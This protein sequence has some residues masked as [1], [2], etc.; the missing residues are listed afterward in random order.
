MNILKL[1]PHLPEVVF[2]QLPIVIE[3]Y[4]MNNI[5]RLSHFL[6]QCSHESGYFKRVVENLNYSADGL[7]KIFPS[8]FTP[9]LAQQYARNP[10]K[11]GS[12][13]YANRMGNGSEESGEGYKFRGRGYIQLTGKYN[14]DLFS[15]YMNI[16]FVSNPD[17][18]SEKFGLVCAGWY[19]MNRK[20]NPISD[21]GIDVKTIEEVTKKINPRL[22]GLKDRID[23]TNKFYQILN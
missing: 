12:R 3:K 7:M 10:Q 11:I 22:I 5:L 13:V 18:V 15:R 23:Q 9:Q 19:F 20:I 17:L 21:K 8:Y 1:K 6:G 4:E 16:D 14:Y 2:S